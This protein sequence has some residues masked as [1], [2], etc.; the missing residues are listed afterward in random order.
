MKFLRFAALAVAAFTLSACFD[1]DQ[2]VAVHRDGS[3]HYR[4]AVTAEGELG[5]A[6]KTDKRNVLAPNAAQSA[7]TV[8]G[9]RVTK[10]SSVDFAS[11]SALKLDDEQVSLKVLSA[12]FLGITPS[13]VRFRYVMRIGHVRRAQ[14]GGDEGVSKAVMS[15][16]FGDH[17]YRFTATLPGSIER[18]AKVE[19][20]GVEIKPE[21]SG[22]FYHGHTVRW[23]MPLARMLTAQQIVFE[24]DFSAI[25]AFK[26]VTSSAR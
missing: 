10:T 24:A 20:G 23:Q 18:I 19:I 9:N 13:H 22:D 26:D 7:V 17:H 5:Q 1:L 6:M 11:L 3:G 21:V 12:G 4:V 14:P 8:S 2:D 15:G 25:G 16:M